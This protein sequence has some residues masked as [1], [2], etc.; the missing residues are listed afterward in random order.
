MD[1]DQYTQFVLELA[2]ALDGFLTLCA[3]VQYIAARRL[4]KSF[5]VSK[6]SYFKFELN[7]SLISYFYT[8]SM[9]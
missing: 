8:A 3:S 1:N 9:F 4:Y 6:I 7:V 2:L 5:T